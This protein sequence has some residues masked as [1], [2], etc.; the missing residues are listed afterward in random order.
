MDP[1]RSDWPA[2]YFLGTNADKSYVAPDVNKTPHESMNWAWSIVEFVPRRR[3]EGSRRMGVFGIIVPFFEPRA[4]AEGARLHRSVLELIESSGK[5]P[6]NL[7]ET[8][9]VED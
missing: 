8:F 1:Y 7:P 3:Y 9:A 6:P 2:T 4:I 5:K